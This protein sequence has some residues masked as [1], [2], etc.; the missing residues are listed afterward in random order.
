MEKLG[1]AFKMVLWK[2]NP[3]W[4]KG[5]SVTLKVRFTSSVGIR[6]MRR[7]E[8]DEG[9]ATPLTLAVRG[10]PPCHGKEKP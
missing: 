7:V 8:G 1:S 4:P 10:N 2:I 9:V 6:M 3:I 5:G